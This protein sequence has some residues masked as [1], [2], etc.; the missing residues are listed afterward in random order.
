MSRPFNITAIISDK[1]GRVLSVGKNSYIKTH[2][3]MYR[4]GQKVG[5]PEKI[6]MHAEVDAIIKCRNLRKAHKISVYRYDNKG[7]P[8]MAKPCPIC[9]TAIKEAGI[10]IIEWTSRDKNTASQLS[11]I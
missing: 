6:Y 5:L 1:K 3:M 7:K 2:T 8:A 10:S 11:E 4:L 9:M